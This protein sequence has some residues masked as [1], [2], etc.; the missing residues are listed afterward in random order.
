LK[1]ELVLNYT[2]FSDRKEFEDLKMKKLN[3]QSVNKR[4]KEK[5]I[6]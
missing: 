6:I 1:E 4:L 2:D 3:I 5:I